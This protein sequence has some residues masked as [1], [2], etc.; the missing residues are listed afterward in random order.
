MKVEYEEKSEK[1]DR[2]NRE[3]MD[4]TLTGTKGSDHEASTMRIELLGY[5]VGFQMFLYRTYSW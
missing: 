4:L 3:L 1:V 5:S 2:L